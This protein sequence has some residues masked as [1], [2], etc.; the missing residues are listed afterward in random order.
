[1]GTP[2]ARSC[3]HWSSSSGYGY[4]DDNTLLSN[5]KQN[6]LTVYVRSHFTVANELGSIQKLTLE[7]RFDDGFVAYLNGTEV[8]RA[9]VPAGPMQANTAATGHE[10]T[11]GAQ[12]FPISP[13]LLKAGDNVFAVEVHNASLGSSDLSFIP[14]L[15]ADDGTPA[16]QAT[17]R[18]G[19]LLQQVGRRSTMVVWETVEPAP[20]SLR[21]GTSLQNMNQVVA[22]PNLVTHHLAQLDNLE[23]ATRYFFVIDSLSSPTQPGRFTTVVNHTDPFRLAVFGD[24]RTHHDDHA[25]VIA[26]MVPENP[27]AAFHTGDLVSNGSS[28][29]DWDKFFQLERPLL[30]HTPLHPTIGNHEGEGDIYRDIFELPPDAPEAE[31][32]YTVR[33]A[34]ALFINLD[35]YTSD[36]DPQSQQYA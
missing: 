10:V 21:F 7:A 35:L 25:V 33:F 27:A 4:G 29:S 18:R 32:Y 22:S 12:V 9:S 30:L 34:T 11:D 20:S 14:N 19:P 13:S 5:M 15:L 1:M 23:P 31:R 36:I 2:P 6:Y 24:T 8:A 17:I 26:A 3:R 16:Q 28:A